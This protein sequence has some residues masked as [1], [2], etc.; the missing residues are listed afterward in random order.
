MNMSPEKLKWYNGLT[1]KNEN[2]YAKYLD[3]KLGVSQDDRLKIG[4]LTSDDREILNKIVKKQEKVQRKILRKKESLRKL[5]AKQ[6]VAKKVHFID[7]PKSPQYIDSANSK[8]A[9]SVDSGK[10]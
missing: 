2:V 1:S 4:N 5:R 10:Y 8:Y 6:S 3:L 7:S 9:S